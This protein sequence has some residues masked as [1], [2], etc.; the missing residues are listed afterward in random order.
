[1]GGSFLSQLSQL[2]PLSG[3]RVA[4]PPG[5]GELEDSHS[6]DS[7]V[8]RQKFVQKCKIGMISTKPIPGHGLGEVWRHHGLVLTIGCI[9]KDQMRSLFNWSFILRANSVGRRNWN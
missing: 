1:M 8:S 3:A 9:N 2:A 6:E 5:H 4:K 7:L